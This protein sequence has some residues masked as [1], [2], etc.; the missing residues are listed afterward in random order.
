[1]MVGYG[2]GREESGVAAERSG[3]RTEGFGWKTLGSDLP[4]CWCDM[5][6]GTEGV[7]N[8]DKNEIKWDCTILFSKIK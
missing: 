5:F 8:C 4:N 2:D 7:E 6:L 3:S 1:V